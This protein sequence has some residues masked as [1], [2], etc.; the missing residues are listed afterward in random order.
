MWSLA[1][2]AR[3]LLVLVLVFD[4]VGTPLHAHHHDQAPDGVWMSAALDGD[5]S[6]NAHLD[7]TGLGDAIVHAALAVCPRV[8]AS[9]PFG[10]A[11]EAAIESSALLSLAFLLLAPDE[12]EIRRPARAAPPDIDSYR[13]L[14]PAGRAPPLHS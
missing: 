14:P 10:S 6:A 1:F 3:W 7:A 8:E 13:S 4:Q 5:H 2:W 9:L 12:R 11:S